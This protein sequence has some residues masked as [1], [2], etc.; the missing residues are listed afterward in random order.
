MRHR[1]F[2]S[3]ALTA[4]AAGLGAC[5][6]DSPNSSFSIGRSEAR[7]CLRRMGES[8]KPLERP[9]VI[10]GGIHDPGFVVSS[11]SRQL[12]RLTGDDD[13]F[14]RVSFIGP[15]CDTFDRC[16]EKLIAAVDLAFPT[17]DPAET[18]EVDVIAFSMGGIVSRHAARPPHDG[19]RRLR[20]QRL[21][22]I[23]SPHRGARL[24]G[25]PTLGDQRKIDMRP[26]S[27]FLAGLD[28][29]LEQA[30]YELV[31]YTRLDDLVVGPENT[32]PAD[33]NTTPGS[34]SARIDCTPRAG[35]TVPC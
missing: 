19:G 13:R 29:D 21:F 12:R 8:P 11:I 28:A 14:V 22:T 2:L 26:G 4:S 3:V 18:V 31:T 35:S 6:V 10:V 15:R 27:D 9:V 25:L 33:T 16:R 20:V 5:S 23:S 34:P 1:L 32:A 24:A 30:G 7:D 17:D